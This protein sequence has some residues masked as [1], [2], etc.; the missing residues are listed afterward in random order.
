MNDATVAAI[1][2]MA[3]EV[4]RRLRGRFAKHALQAAHAL[5]ARPE[6][7]ERVDRLP[8]KPGDT[9]IGLGDSITDDDQSWLEI[10]RALLQIRRSEDRI[11]IVNAGISGDTTSQMISRFLDVTLQKPDWIIC[12]AGTNDARRHGRWPTKVLV[13]IEETKKNL[14]M[15]RN[16]AATQT[17][18]HRVWMTPTPVIE[19]QIA[20]DWFLGPRQLLWS[21]EDLAA[22]ASAVREQP[23]LVVD[24]WTAFGVPPDPALLLPDGLHPSLAGQSSIVA[25]LVDRLAAR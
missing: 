10:L 7:A 23:D 22:I 3:V 19:D 1:F 25:A 21:N 6:F 2:G 12:M 9:V 15:L 5:L 4:Y 17:S 20:R 16:F 24:L 14:K 13:S 8:F 11:Q 18:A